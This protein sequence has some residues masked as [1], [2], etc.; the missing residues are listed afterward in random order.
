MTECA[1]GC[2]REKWSS[3][4]S[5]HMQKRANEHAHEGLDGSINGYITEGDMEVKQIQIVAPSPAVLYTRS[6]GKSF[7]LF[8]FQP[9]PVSTK[10]QSPCSVVLQ[11]ACNDFPPKS[12]RK[13]V[14][15]TAR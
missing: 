12:Q 11:H 10:R 9:L 7:T 15:L 6:S 1:H 2:M 8:I 13:A 3:W 5:M 14:L 4:D